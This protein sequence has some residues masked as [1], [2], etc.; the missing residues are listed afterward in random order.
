MRINYIIKLF[1]PEQ[2]AK[3]FFVF[4][5]LFFNGQL[6]NISLLLQC[7]VAF[8]AFSFAASSIYCFNDIYYVASDRL[9]PKKCKRSIASGEIS[10]KTAFTVMALCLAM[11]M[12][13][14]LLFGVVSCIYKAAR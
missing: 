2:W 1:R 5:P 9:H 11:S 14:L 3:N 13:I 10:I 8:F 7:F 12:L 4:L 6:L